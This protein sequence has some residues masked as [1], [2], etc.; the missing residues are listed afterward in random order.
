LTALG[1]DLLEFIDAMGLRQPAL[2][3]HDWGARAAAIACG[4]R[5]CVASHLVMLSVGYGTND[6]S[7][8]LSLEQARNYWY[9][10]YMATPRGERTVRENRRAFARI[11]WDT[12]AP[13]GWFT[14]DEF[15]ATARAFDNDDW[16]DITLHS[17]R[18]RWG[19]TDG[20]PLY[21]GDEAAMSPA[22][23]LQVPTLVLH[24]EHDTVNHPSMSA[25]KES[26]FRGIYV[27]RLLPGVGHFP[28]REAPLEVLSQLR[29]FLEE[30][31]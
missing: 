5:P 3:G 14:E 21:G 23:V 28:Q 4:L 17:Y 19:H 31:R 24:G 9:H 16:P 26:Y 30:G 10:W 1:R 2:V 7:Q 25:G 20:D 18:H 11:M 27:R 6:A 13:P 29:L 22:P 12:W 15:E 8:E